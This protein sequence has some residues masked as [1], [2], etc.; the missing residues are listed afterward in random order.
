M[1]ATSENVLGVPH[2][3][4]AESRHRSSPGFLCGKHEFGFRHSFT[5]RKSRSIS[6]SLVHT[7]H[8]SPPLRIQGRETCG[9]ILRRVV[10]EIIK[11]A[12]PAGVVATRRT[13][14]PSL[15]RPSRVTM[16]VAAAFSNSGRNAKERTYL[17]EVLPEK[18]VEASTFPSLHQ[19]MR[20]ERIMCPFQDLSRRGCRSLQ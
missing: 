14:S 17:V 11:S 4:A 5:I 12:V 7:N 18:V 8:S 1:E 16:V 9:A 20:A 19:D 6:R 2:D 13:C 15:R 10:G 3:V